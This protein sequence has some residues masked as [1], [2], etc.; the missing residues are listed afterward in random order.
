MRWLA[1]VGNKHVLK[2]NCWHFWFKKS[3]RP[4]GQVNILDNG[5]GMTIQISE[6]NTFQTKEGI[7]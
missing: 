5:Q 6:H 4:F 1:K 7:L 3:R 2:D